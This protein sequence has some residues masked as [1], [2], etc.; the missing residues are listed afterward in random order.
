VEGPQVEVH[1]AAHTFERLDAWLTQVAT[2]GCCLECATRQC[3]ERIHAASCLQRLSGDRQIVGAGCGGK[4]DRRHEFACWLCT[5]LACEW[6][7]ICLSSGRRPRPRLV[8]G[9]KQ[10]SEVTGELLERPA[11]ICDRVGGHARSVDAWHRLKHLNPVPVNDACRVVMAAIAEASCAQLGR[12]QKRMVLWS[13]KR[14]CC[15]REY[16]GRKA[17]SVLTHAYD[18]GMSA[19]YVYEDFVT[20]EAVIHRG[21]CRHCNYGHGRGAGRNERENTWHGEFSSEQSARAGGINPSSH[22][23]DCRVCMG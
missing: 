13:R 5:P 18:A 20:H 7:A 16:A 1:V 3:V 21:A 11:K 19:W 15:G 22:L 10:C 9:T 6:F 23:R 4:G 17:A 14:R 8:V 2:L 12:R